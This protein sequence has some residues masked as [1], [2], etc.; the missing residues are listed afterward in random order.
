MAGNG[1][2]KTNVPEASPELKISESFGYVAEQ[3]RVQ[4]KATL[5]AGA[6]PSRVDPDTRQVRYNTLPVPL[7]RLFGT[8]LEV[9]SDAPYVVP[10]RGSGLYVRQT[11]GTWG[12][13]RPQYG[14]G[15]RPHHGLDFRA[16]AGESVLA[17]GDG[18]IN[19]VGVQR[20]DAGRL[21][22][23]NPRQDPASGDV[24]GMV[25]DH[26]VVVKRKELGFGGLY[27]EIRHDKG[28]FR[29]FT[30]AYMHLRST[31]AVETRVVSEGDVIGAAGTS[32]GL[33]GMVAEHL[34]WQLNLGSIKNPIDPR[35]YVL[36]SR[37]G[38]ASEGPSSD[39]LVDTLVALQ[40]SG[41]LMR[42]QWATITQ[43]LGDLRANHRG[44]DAENETT[45][46]RR[47]CAAGFQQ[48]VSKVNGQAGSSVEQS[49]V[50]YDPTKKQ[51]IVMNAMA[52]DFSTGLWIDPTDTKH[53][54][55]GKAT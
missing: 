10:L 24:T 18:V 53:T 7:R 48:Y 31:D 43:K 25:G 12:D 15:S 9:K 46:F 40:R 42:G 49:M 33:N 4:E 2:I 54:S 30:T 39:V 28:D 8:P 17:A 52:Y 22:L 47:A 20:K 21:S 1:D 45:A 5:N 14:G 37:V 55:D 13:T 34:H 32:G 3:S 23:S 36:H 6:T 44:V 38:D 29:G 51:A 41:K 11:T 27:V 26:T 19:F 35:A 16:V 50:K